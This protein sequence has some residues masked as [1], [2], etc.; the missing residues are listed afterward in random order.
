ME[1]DISLK[2]LSDTPCFNRADLFR[3]IEYAYPGLT[4]S[5]FKVKLQELL[6]TEKIIRVGRNAYCVSQNGDC[7]YAHVY[8]ETAQKIADFIQSEYKYL[9][10]RIFELIQLNE[11]LNHQ[12]AHNSI[13]VAVES[14]LEDFVFDGLKEKYGK[15]VFVNPSVEMYHRYLMDDMIVIHKLGT[16]TPKGSK[17][18]WHTGLEKMLVDIMCDKIIKS[19]F[20]EAELPEIF[21]TAFGNYA[22]DESK[23]FRYGKRRTADKKI[24]R[25]LNEKTNVKLRLK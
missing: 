8:S 4:E 22:I 9:D 14:E 10:F 24:K 1:V 16:E 20:S 25:F 6:K 18:F 17:E 5:N 3:E 7:V 13:F 11:F 19:T 15:Q 12:L 23:M 21:E 2:H